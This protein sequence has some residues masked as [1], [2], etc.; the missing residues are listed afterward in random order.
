[1]IAVEERK[2]RK[3]LVVLHS[4]RIAILAALCLVTAIILLFFPAPLSLL[5][6]LAAL[7]AAILVSVLFLPLAR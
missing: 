6:V 4:V 2:L 7:L 1:M 3:R 5:A